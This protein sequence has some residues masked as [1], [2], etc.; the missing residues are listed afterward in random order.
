MT[1]SMWA[2]VWEWNGPPRFLCSL[3]NLPPPPS[4]LL[5][6]TTAAQEANHTRA[7]SVT[8]V[9]S[10]TPNYCCSI[11]PSQSRL[12]AFED[13]WTCFL[14][15]RK[16]KKNISNTN[17]LMSKSQRK[18]PRITLQM[19]MG[20]NTAKA[21]TWLEVISTDKCRKQLTRHKQNHKYY[22]E[23]SGWNRMQP[24]WDLLQWQ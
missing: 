11:N 8:E 20:P 14:L 9:R 1:D 16:K 24:F 5:L 17:D 4:P 7:F 10:W 15:S 13:L 3:L 6:P 21:L 23:K 19:W 22:L 2:S 18:C 12:R